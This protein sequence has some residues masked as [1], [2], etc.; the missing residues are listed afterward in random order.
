[1]PPKKKKGERV[2]SGKKKK[3]EEKRGAEPVSEQS[4]D[5][6]L[7]QIRDLEG[8]LE[9]YQ[10]KSDEISAREHLIQA[11]C[12][13]LSN[14]KKEIVSFL[15]RTLNQRMDE[16][17]DLN[18]QLLG[19]QQ[20]KDAET[21][22]YEAQLAYMRH[23]FQ[24][25]KDRLTSENMLL[26]GK[27]ASLEEFRVQKEELMANF[28]VLEEK[29]KKR[30]E[31]HKEMIYKLEKKSM[32]DKDR[33]KKEMVQH[34]N[35]V[36]AEFCRV[37]NDL[38][39]EST[40]RTIRENV[41]I[42]S[43]LT[44]MSDKSMELMQQNENLNDSRSELRKQL[45]VLEDNEKKLVKNNL[46]NQK[47]IQMLNEKCQ[48]QQ[49]MLGQFV[50]TQ[51]DLNQL[52]NEHHI[53]QEEARALKQRVSCLEE[54]VQRSMQEKNS[55]SEQL[56]EERE[57]KQ[58]VESVLGQAAAALKDMLLD[59]TKD[60]EEDVEVMYQTRQ[61][62]MLRNLLLLLNSSAT[63]G[64][65]PSLHEFKAKEEQFVE[66]N[67][68]SKAQR[69]P[70]ADQVYNP[71]YSQP[72]YW[73]VEDDGICTP[74]KLEG[75]SLLPKVAGKLFPTAV[76]EEKL[77]EA[78]QKSHRRI[79]GSSQVF[80]NFNNNHL[81]HKAYSFHDIVQE[82]VTEHYEC[83]LKCL[84]REEWERAVI[85]LSKAINLDPEMV[86]LYV[87][88]AEAFLQLCDF[89]SAV[90][91][92]QK[93]CSIGEPQ[94]EVLD[95]LAFTFY[96]QGQCLF[97]KESYLD[98][99]DSF[100]RGS[101]LQPWNSH[102]HM[103]SISCLAALG[104]HADCIR[105]V[106]KQLEGE[107]RNP[108]LYVLRARLYDHLNQ[109]TPCYQ[110]VQR[111]L[112]LDPQHQEGRNLQ[113]KL[114]SKAEETKMA[115]V[116]CAVQGYLQDALKK[117]C[118]AIEFHPSSAEYHIFRGT[119]YRRLKDFSAAVDDFVLAIE[120]CSTQGTGAE[121]LHSEAEKHLLLTYNDFAVH[122][123]TKGFYQEGVLLLNKALKGET[124]WKELYINRGD[125]FFQLGEMS[126]ALEDYQQALELDDADWGIRT[127]I[128]RLLDEMGIR[129]QRMRQY[130]QAENH[131]SEALKKQPLLPQLYLHRAQARRCLQNTVD[132]QVDAVIS[133]L[134]NPKSDEA[135]QTMMNYFP[136][137]TLDE[138]MSSKLA[139]LA[140][141][142]LD[143]SLRDLPHSW[144]DHIHS[145]DNQE[146]ATTESK[147]Q[148]T[149][150]GIAV[151]VSDRQLA[152]QL[153][154]SRKK[155]NAEIQDVLKRRG[156][157]QDNTS[158]LRAKP[159]LKEKYD[160]AAPYNWKTFGLGLTQI[161]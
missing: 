62:Q 149:N 61:N 108:D 16:I 38:M 121:Q 145:L 161:V 52:Q 86:E 139:D 123:Y 67:M 31:E 27:L 32:L 30:E 130:Q 58:A 60:E 8:R 113:D 104:R 110:D 84:S 1:M 99:L 132:A 39:A 51:R 2:A 29:L 138:I 79:F 90:L 129:A 134:L 136:S 37:S 53:L 127:R 137:K 131:Y 114:M 19:L 122:C 140:R 112:A 155:L 133:I 160:P 11:Q 34:V 4:K 120:L 119:L 88:R 97:E 146:V 100:T 33:L 69:G 3:E 74:M 14:D 70:P 17:A 35:S 93:A 78:R 116:K 23:E 65:G 159:R 41:S 117:I 152:A 22:A 73:L 44:K 55:L 94:E 10:K 18:D 47:L 124:N 141:C 153:I 54:E 109:A 158:R 82:K 128:A 7:M 75:I 64:L 6:Y 68:A 135:L 28:A 80:L 59:K 125:C 102:Y 148:D 101:E 144:E 106:S 105:L 15:K 151:C 83:A 46:S 95:L 126:F 36:A 92:L 13:Q 157:L 103:R 5:F 49:E 107:Q 25:T 20:A 147:A 48:K 12:E 42:R 89:Q 71:H 156:Q 85:S 118:F 91:N 76:S 45:E 142:V 98:A 40:K 143:R 43:Q 66:Y 77:Q 96:L 63:L 9:R 87:R 81:E 56:K 26:A 24:V 21:E 50:E 111:A 57:R 72:A 150:K 115:A 154:H